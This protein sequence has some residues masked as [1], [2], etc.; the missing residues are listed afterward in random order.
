MTTHPKLEKFDLDLL[1]PFEEHQYYHFIKSMTKPEALQILINSVE[2]D[3]TQ[4]SPQLA[5][6]AEEQ[7]KELN[8]W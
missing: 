3:F 7:N 8:L 2:G 5:E 4:L 6:I 1:D